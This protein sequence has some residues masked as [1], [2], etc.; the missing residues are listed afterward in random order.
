MKVIEYKNKKLK[1]PYDLK[2]GE[3]SNRA[4]TTR[5]KPIQRSNQYELPRNSRR[6]Y[7]TQ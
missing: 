3:T 1:L 2:D 4:M 7:M 5:H 6:L